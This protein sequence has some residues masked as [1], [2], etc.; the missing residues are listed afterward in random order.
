MKNFKRFRFF[1]EKQCRK[2][3]IV[4]EGECLGIFVKKLFWK[5]LK[6]TALGT[7]SVFAFKVF[8]IFAK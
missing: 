8:S 7:L 6:N 3:G 2:I 4:F 5:I 1:F